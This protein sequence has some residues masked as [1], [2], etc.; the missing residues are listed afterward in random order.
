[1][2]RNLN[3]GGENEDGMPTQPA[4]DER[5][6]IHQLKEG[7]ASAAGMLMDHYGESLMRYLLSILANREAAEDAF[8][9]CWVKVM[10]KIG[11]FQEVMSFGPWLFRI[12]RNTAYDALR[13]KRRW[14]S[15]DSGLE[16]D[17]EERLPEVADPTDFGNQVV[18]RQTVERLIKSLSPDY[19]EVLYLRFFESQSYE[20]IAELCRLPLGT[21]K[22]RL[23]RGL[24]LLAAN[25]MGAK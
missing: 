2:G 6:W 25:I 12:A 19:R 10:E 3:D 20:E 15:L 1:M 9:D 7:Q 17:S 13:R 8:Q 16:A 18:A 24:D 4:V 23:K 5:R 14:R 22:S 21:V 11:Q